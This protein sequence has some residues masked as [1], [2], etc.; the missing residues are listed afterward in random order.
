MQ[1]NAA[2]ETLREFKNLIYAQNTETKGKARTHDFLAQE[3]PIRSGNSSNSFKN[4]GDT[5]KG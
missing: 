3:L 4:L 5:A 1:S 2:T